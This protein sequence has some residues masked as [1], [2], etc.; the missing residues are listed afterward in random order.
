MYFYI[1][2]FI[3]TIYLLFYIYFRMRFRFWSIQPVFHFHNLWY[4]LFPPGIIQHTAF[5]PNKHVNHYNIIVQKFSLLSSLQQEEMFHLIKNNYLVYDQMTYT[6]T[7]QNVLSYFEYHNS[8]SYIALY[9]TN[10]VLHDQKTGTF[11]PKKNIS[12]VLTSRPLHIT[13][14][15]YNYF[16]S[17]YVDYL[18]VKKKERR[19]GIAPQLIATY[20]YE[21]RKANSDI[22]TFVFKREG[23]HTPIVPIVVYKSYMYD[24]HYWIST[25]RYPRPYR[26]THISKDNIQLLIRSLETQY[27]TQT[28]HCVIMSSLGNISHLIEMNILIPYVIHNGGNVLAIYFYRDGCVRYKKGKVIDLVGSV[29][30]DKDFAEFFE[31]GLFK[32]V[33]ELKK[34]HHYQYFN[35]E[36]LS[37][38]NLLINNINKTFRPLYEVPYSYYFYN[39]AHRPF[40]NQDVFVLC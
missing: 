29:L 16:I 22:C 5:K 23:E 32:S 37:H 30:I 14:F 15:Q 35:V 10:S 6:P 38:N 34:K 40:L 3:A 12:G 27:I 19:K 21:A 9:T 28:F 33:V 7:K 13:L 39:F 11:V 17:H 8:P 26:L 25:T 4:W 31:L 18:C 20:A 24:L 36:N 1:L 2:S